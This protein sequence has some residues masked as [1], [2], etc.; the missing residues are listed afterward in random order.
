MNY[1]AYGNVKHVNNKRATKVGEV[2][3]PLLMFFICKSYVF[4]KNFVLNSGWTC[5]H[6]TLS[7]IITSNFEKRFC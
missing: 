2:R 4:I 5:H 3:K 1:D 6:N 7:F